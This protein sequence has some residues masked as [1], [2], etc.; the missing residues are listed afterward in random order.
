MVVALVSLKDSPKLRSL[1][2]AEILPA[3][4]AGAYVREYSFPLDLFECE[5]FQGYDRPLSGKNIF[6]IGVFKNVVCQ[7][8]FCPIAKKTKKAR[9]SL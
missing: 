8:K 7:R 6:P 2:A 9:A 1:V 5:L 3:G 4:Y